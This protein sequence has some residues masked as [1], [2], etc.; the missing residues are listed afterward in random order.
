MAKNLENVNKR[1]QV[2]TKWGILGFFEYRLLYANDNE[3][4]V[5]VILYFLNSYKVTHIE[6]IF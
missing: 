4:T 6:L 1:P 5:L 3:F 2:E